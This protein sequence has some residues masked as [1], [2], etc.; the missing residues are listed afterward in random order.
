MIL[1]LLCDGPQLQTQSLVH[2]GYIFLEGLD[3]LG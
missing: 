3:I 2:A 1:E